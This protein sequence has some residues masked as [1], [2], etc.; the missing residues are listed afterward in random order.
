MLS[1]SSYRTYVF[2]STG[3]PYRSC[4]ET[5]SGRICARDV[6]QQHELGAPD[7]SCCVIFTLG[8][9][10]GLYSIINRVHV[11]HTSYIEET[12]IPWAASERHPG[13]CSRNIG[14]KARPTQ[15]MSRA[16]TTIE[17][18]TPSVPVL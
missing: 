18:T 7:D 4:T 11:Y 12:S 17:M 6:S 2:I 15:G 13:D 3:V 8:I 9:L 1:N 14:Y 16:R 10:D 5:A